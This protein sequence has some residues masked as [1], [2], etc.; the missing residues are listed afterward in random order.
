MQTAADF[1]AP[2]IAQ[3]LPGVLFFHGTL[4]QLEEGLNKLPLRGQCC[5]LNDS[6]R[7]TVA[8]TATGAQTVASTVTLLLGIKSHPAWSPEQRNLVQRVTLAQARVLPAAFEAAGATV[9]GALQGD[10]FFNLF[11]VNIDGCQVAYQLQLPDNWDYCI[12]EIPEL[13]EE[14]ADTEPGLLS[15]THPLYQEPL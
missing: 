1:L 3:A 15:L 7:F 2:V 4:K 12:P 13:P 11:A 10:T 5:C 14:P 9:L 6:I 8:T